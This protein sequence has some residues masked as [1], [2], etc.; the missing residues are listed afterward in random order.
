MASG[1]GVGFAKE[2][3]PTMCPPADL[4]PHAHLHSLCL[5]SSK[6]LES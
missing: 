2:P 3:V 4:D 1:G 5:A 6:H